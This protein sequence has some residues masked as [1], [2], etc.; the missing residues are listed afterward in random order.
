MCLIKFRVFATSK[1]IKDVTLPLILHLRND[2][3]ETPSSSTREGVWLLILK[4]ELGWAVKHSSGAQ[5]ELYQIPCQV[6]SLGLS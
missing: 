1:H 5:E 3:E 4:T 6:M 2:E